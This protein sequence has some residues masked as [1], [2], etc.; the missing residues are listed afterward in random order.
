MLEFCKS[1]TAH[2]CH[3]FDCSS[4]LEAS[5]NQC[6]ISSATPILRSASATAD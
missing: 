6:L 2:E 3:V 5:L 4:L 1:R